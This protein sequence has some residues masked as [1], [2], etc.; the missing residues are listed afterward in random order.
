MQSEKEK[1]KE[2]FQEVPAI[3]V[4]D[5][6]AQSP[7]PVPIS[8]Q[9]TLEEAL[10]MLRALQPNKSF[11]DIAKKVA[12]EKILDD[13]KQ[14]V[15]KAKAD[16]T[17]L[18]NPILALCEI[19]PVPKTSIDFIKIKASLNSVDKKFTVLDG[20]RQIAWTGS[21]TYSNESIL[22]LIKAIESDLPAQQAIK[23]FVV[24]HIENY[25]IFAQ[26]INCPLSV[27][28][29]IINAIKEISY[30]IPVSVAVSFTLTCRN[31]VV[32]IP[33]IAESMPADGNI[34]P[35]VE[36]HVETVA[37][38]TLDVFIGGDAKTPSTPRTQSTNVTEHAARGKMV[39]SPVKGMD[40]YDFAMLRPDDDKGKEFA[41]ADIDV[42]AKHG[43]FKWNFMGKKREADLSQEAKDKFELWV[44]LSHPNWK[45]PVKD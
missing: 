9:P 16:V 41:L 1:K 13:R 24:P 43:L 35:K 30:D 40:W 15:V 18:T 37:K 25:G 33:E 14:A 6:Q 23:D 32:D 5:D 44:Q 31:Q 22:A 36:K 2:K 21:G 4:Q 19:I 7:V 39:L 20:D 3:N 28:D 11:A 38:W 12:E 29:P 26:K 34:I 8:T 27:L 45:Y 42:Q 17:A 10:A